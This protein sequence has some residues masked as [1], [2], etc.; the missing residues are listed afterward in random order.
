[1]KKLEAAHHKFQRR[2][3]GIS[4]KDKV[5][6]DDIKRKTGLRKLEDSQRTKTKMVGTCHTNGGL[7]NT[8]PDY[9]VGV[10]RIQEEARTT[11]DKLD[12]H[13]ETQ[14]E[15]MDITWEEAKELAADR[16]EWRQRV[17]QCIQQNRQH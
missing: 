10:E 7:Q 13:R 14:P 2:L 16:T 15:N 9:T 1:M 12:G 4:W 5:K 3:L 11:K 8:S 6:N 17:A